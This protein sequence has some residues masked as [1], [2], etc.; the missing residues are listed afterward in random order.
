MLNPLLVVPNVWHSTCDVGATFTDPLMIKL[1]PE[2]QPYYVTVCFNRH[3]PS[4]LS[5]ANNL[6]MNR[7]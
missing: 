1:Q 7:M 3:P 6:S 5:L 4:S 2:L